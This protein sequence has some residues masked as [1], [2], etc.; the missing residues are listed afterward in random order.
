MDE[1]ERLMR[2]ALQLASEPPFT[3]PNPRVGAVIARN[4]S[5]VS[6][7]V[8][9]GA[10]T[11]H[12]EAVALDGVDAAGATLYVNLEPCVHQGRMP[13][14]A[15]LVIAAGVGR[16]VVAVEDP[17]P[18]VAGKGMADLNA[19][20][21]EVVVGVCADEARRLN[22][23]YLHQRLTG[24]PLMT[25]KL[26]LSLDGKIAAA[27]GSSRWITGETARHRVHERRVEVD[28]LL[29][30]AG[31]VATDDPSLTARDVE[32]RRQPVRVVCDAIGKVPAT[33][34]IFA[35]GD[36]IV[37]TTAECDQAM[38]S[39]WK[40]AGAEVVDVPQAVGGGVDLTV[41][42]ENLAGRGW[43]EVLCEGGGEIA[44]SLLRLDLVDR[45]DL[46]YGPLLIGGTG[47]GLGDLGIESMDEAS[48]WHLVEVQRV[49]DDVVS[50][51]ERDR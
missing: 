44:T 5:I 17:D 23:S 48:R 33:S 15:P 3:S 50:T 4:G 7:G 47:V 31:T 16:V 14:C 30:G 28:A 2:R 29:V 43:L 36:V 10:G 37:M 9:Q 35:G 25:L 32:A 27:D 40:D 21:L 24:K 1:D 51:L 18:R 45:L 26:A 46:N 11:A 12:A 39:A 34:K 8:H 49:G 22:R 20:G 6:E 38:R 41:V 19:A 13:P 42:I